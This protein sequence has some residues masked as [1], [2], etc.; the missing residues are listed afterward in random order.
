MAESLRI[1]VLED[2]PADAEL[3]QFELEE[4]GFRF[5]S[6]VVEA[7]NDFIRE[8]QEFSPDLILS[9]YDLPKYNGALALAESKRRCPGT[10]VILVTGAVTED[11]AIEILTQGA[12][13][14]V[15]KQRLQQRLVPAVQRALSEAEEQRARKQAEAELRE[16]HRTLER[17]VDERTSELRES[18]ARLS[19]ALASSGMGTFEWD[20][21]RNTRL[22]D[23]N[24]FRLLGIKPENFSGEAE[25]VFEAMHPDDRQAVRDAQ[26]KAIEQDVFYETEYRAV[27]PDGSVHHIAA[28]GKVLRD[29][30]G[31][32]LRMIGVCW[33]ITER[34]RMEAKM[35]RY[36]LLAAHTRDIVLFIRRDD[37]RI[38]EANAAAV[39]AY[40][41]GYDE[42]LARTIHDL[43]PPDTQRLTAGQLEEA[44]KQGILFQTRHM[45][46]DG[47]IFPVEVS[48]KG[49]TIGGE[50]MLISVIRDITERRR[51]EEALRESRER[52]RA[53][54]DGMAEGFAVHEIITD[55]QGA[56]VDYRVLDVN[57]AFERL[58]GLKREN[59]VGKTR[60]EVLPGDDPVWLQRF[61]KVALGGE[62]AQFEDYSAALKRRYR[63]LAYSP[64][65]RRFAVIFMDVGGRK[66][67]ETA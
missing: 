38:M 17:Q 5:T 29:D 39:D 37:G 32:P 11:R 45:R 64:A 3:A 53:L 48:S 35:R 4:A 33:E 60:N 19:L 30:A 7:E 66:T 52:Y 6:K 14:Y 49:A 9:D 22:F 63:V 59:V 8:L 24:V 57:P 54:F 56:P 34:K 27:W 18:K 31:L 47:T 41:H 42:L 1:L 36:E 25:E 15:L 65:P 2:N 51:A 46:S 40:G 10:P 13:D 58:T 12:K 55:Q 20:L 26:K 44:E 67:A 61:G 50:H 23:D 62:P 16:A 21:V 43:R 28:R